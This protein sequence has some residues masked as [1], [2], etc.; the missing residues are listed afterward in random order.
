MRVLYEHDINDIEKDYARKYGVDISK[1]HFDTNDLILRVNMSETERLE[2]NPCEDAVIDTIL[3]SKSSFKNDFACG[4]FIDKIRDLPPVTQ[5]SLNPE[6]D[7]EESKAY[8][9]EC[10]HIEMCSWYPHDGCEWLKTDR[11]NAGY[12]AAKR[13][14]ALSGEYERA[15][16]RGKQDAEQTRWIPVSERVPQEC[17]HTYDNNFHDYTCSKSVL[18]TIRNK[19]TNSVYVF[20]DLAYISNGEWYIDNCYDHN[21]F[22][23]CSVIAWMPLPEPYRAESEE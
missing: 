13:E 16:E 4:F 18:V 3:S 14:I 19:V 17:I 21:R 7:R 20:H 10:D 1:V 5:R 9:A 11:Y 15:Y 23:N 22:K 6:T 12:N 2:Q 8:C